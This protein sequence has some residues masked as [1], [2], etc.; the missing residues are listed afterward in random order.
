MKRRQF[1]QLPLG[2]STLTVSSLARDAKSSR[3]EVLVESDADRDSK[4]FKFLDATFQVKLSGKDTEGRCVI[5]NTVRHEKRGPGLHFH[6]DCDEWFFVK[7]GQ[8]KFRVGDKILR[9]KAG[10]SL[11]VPKETIHAFVK[12]SDGDATLIIMHQPA[13]R[14]EEY[15]RYASQQ[16]D[17]SLDSRKRIAEQYGFHIVGPSLAPD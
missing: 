8:F 1:V 5:F 16:P 4:P 3:K 15:F 11:L 17:Q 2:A 9:L 10:D 7:D 13:V 14:M 6:T 12:T